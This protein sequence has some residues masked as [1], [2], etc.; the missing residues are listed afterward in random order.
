MPRSKKEQPTAAELNILRV[1][2][3]T[4]PSRLSTICEVLSRKRKLAPTTV[5]TVLKVMKAK[6][7][8]KRVG[9]RPSVVWKAILSRS[10]VGSTIPRDLMDRVF[11]GSARKVILHLMESGELSAEDQ[12]EIR[13]LLASKSKKRKTVELNSGRCG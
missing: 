12:T 1:L 5:A 11:E 10:D 2:W 13:R 9:T 6:G 8:V 3:T 7:Q 4:G